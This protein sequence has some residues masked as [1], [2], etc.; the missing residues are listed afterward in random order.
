[1]CA[2]VIRSRETLLGKNS[3]NLVHRT[4]WPKKLGGNRA[5]CQTLESN[6]AVFSPFTGG[7]FFMFSV[8]FSVLYNEQFISNLADRFTVGVLGVLE[9]L[10]VKIFANFKNFEMWFVV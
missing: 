1:M 8:M 2:H 3:K 7:Q 10:L 4:L 6:S 5:P 9:V